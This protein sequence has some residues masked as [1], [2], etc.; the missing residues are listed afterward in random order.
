MR[1]LPTLRQLRYLVAL[2]EHRHFG[3]AAEACLATQSTLSAGLQELETLLGVT[4]VERTK[5]KVML[6]PLGET[7]VERARELLRQAEDIADLASA[8]S[9]AP[10]SGLL[11]LGVIPTIA[12]YV[13]PQALPHLRESYPDLKLYLREDLTARL[14]D[15]LQAGELDVILLALP[16]GGLD[17]ETTI[18]GEDPFVVV[19]P[20]DHPLAHQQTIANS[21]LQREELLLLEE[22]HCMREHALAACNMPGPARGDGLLA[23]SLVTLVQMVDNGL[24]VT[25]LPNMALNSPI[26]AGTSL[27]TRPLRTAGARQIGLVWR[28]SSPRHSD[29]QAL[30]DF[31]R[32]SGLCGKAAA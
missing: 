13:L 27:V 21:D 3:R 7:V 22:G 25:L 24:G 28:P 20:S 17:L 12:P 31:L 15:R 30:G 1:I 2:D 23:T 29:Y 16:Y 8:A 4:L 14:V 26:L 19:C 6:T 11:R 32:Q 9:S 5:R 10:L 18:I